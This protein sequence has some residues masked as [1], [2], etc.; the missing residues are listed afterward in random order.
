MNRRLFRS[1]LV[2][3]GAALAGG[4]G[5]TRKLSEEV[6]APEGSRWQRAWVETVWNPG[7]THSTEFGLATSDPSETRTLFVAGTSREAQV[8]LGWTPGKSQAEVVLRF[9]P[10]GRALAVTLDG[11]RIWRYVCLDAGEAPFL[12]THVNLEGTGESLWA[13]APETR[14]LCLEVLLTATGGPPPAGGASHF[15]A[16]ERELGP[17]AQYAL[18][19]AAEDPEL[20]R[21]FAR[22]FFGPRA[23]PYSEGGYTP[24]PGS[25]AHFAAKLVSSHED[26]RAVFEAGLGGEEVSNAA[27]VLALVPDARTADALASALRTACAGGERSEARRT[28]AFW[29]A[30]ALARVAIALEGGSDAAIAAL[31]AALGDGSPLVEK[32]PRPLKGESMTVAR[33]ED[34]AARRF[35]VQG[36]AAL[37]RSSPAARAALE[38]IAAGPRRRVRTLTGEILEEEATAAGFSLEFRDLGT[39]RCRDQNEYR[40]PACWARA[41]LQWLDSSEAR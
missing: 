4:C 19:R 38:R 23:A 2:C 26:V 35:A 6:L 28:R 21:A 14:A 41:A 37:A 12:C 11:G 8:A 36:L 40:E 32:D 29:L 20:R 13:R 5:S 10:D 27:A 1:A 30:W 31:E 7:G 18:A 34:S 15:D 3:C 9:T 39:E 16:A 33:S 25:L 22:V 24:L 17:A